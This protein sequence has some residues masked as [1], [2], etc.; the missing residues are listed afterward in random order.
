MEKGSDSKAQGWVS[1]LIAKNTL[2][3]MVNVFLISFRFSLH[4]L[5]HP[6]L[7]MPQNFEKCIFVNISKTSQVVHIP[8]IKMFPVVK[9]CEV[10]NLQ[11]ET[12]NIFP[13]RFYNHPVQTTF[14]FFFLHSQRT[15]KIKHNKLPN[16][17]YREIKLNEENV[18]YI[19]PCFIL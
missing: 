4:F 18:S 2:E 9:A 16:L 1:D 15:K 12:T 3:F 13:Q 11:Q 6:S 10:T 5:Y 19:S 7:K 8:P 14:S 17:L